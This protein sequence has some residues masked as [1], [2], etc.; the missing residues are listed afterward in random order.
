VGSLKALV[1]SIRL[2]DKYILSVNVVT[3]GTRVETYNQLLSTLF[4]IFVRGIV[5]KRFVCYP[6]KFLRW[7]QKLACHL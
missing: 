3:E 7:I 1:L 5:E 2:F 6:R 4:S